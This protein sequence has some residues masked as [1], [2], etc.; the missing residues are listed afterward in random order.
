MFTVFAVIHDPRRQHPTTLPPLET[1]LTITILATICGAQNGVEIA[2]WGQAQEAWRAELLDR[3]QGIP[4]HDTFGR[5]FAVLEPESL[6]PALVRWM[7]ALART[8]PMH[9]VHP[10]AAAHELVLAPGTVDATTKALTAL[11]AWLRL[12]NLAGAVVT[13][14]AMGC[15]AEIARQMQAQ[16]ADDVL[17]VKEK[18]PGLYRDGDDRCTWRRGAHPCEQPVACG[19]AAPV[20][21]GHGRLETRRLGSPEAREGVVSS[22]RLAGR[23]SR[24]MV[25]SIRQLGERERVERR[26]YLSSLP[27]AC[28]EDAQRLKRVM[29]TPW[30]IETRVPWVLDVTLGAD[31]NRTRTGESAQTLA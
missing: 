24:S 17:S 16:G 26:A 5:V 1:I 3:I 11:P 8:G 22:E 29:R 31:G 27:G 18:Q 20:D 15:Q 9:V 10:W 19:G 28:D 23:T 21:G 6:Q 4:S 7:K 30:E 13:S 25:E 2:P 12:L 14:D